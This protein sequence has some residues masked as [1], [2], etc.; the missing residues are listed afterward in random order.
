MLFAL[1]LIPVIGLLIYIYV[2]DKNEKEP[3]G[4]LIGLF[5]AGMATVITAI[6]AELIGQVILE[7]IF[8]Y[9][10]V[11]K[12]VLFAMIVVG[13][14]EELGMYVGLRLITWKSKHF[15]YSY[16]A[17]VYA[18]F[19]SL[20]FAALENIEYVFSNGIG[21]AILRMFTAI[22]GHACFAVFMGYFYSK[23]K[24]A[25]IKGDKKGQSK[26][27]CLSIFLPM[28]IHGIYDA[29]IMGGE[30]SEYDILTGLSLLLWI[31]YIIF[32]FTFSVIIVNKASKNDFCI[33]M[34]PQDI[35]TIYRP[36][37]IGKWKC[38]CGAENSLNFCSN[39]GKA[40]PVGDTWNCPRCGTLS[41]FKF[42][43]NCGT[44]KPAEAPAGQSL[45]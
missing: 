5:F 13:P 1:A 41:A 31:G 6:I 19:V 24:Y 30:A 44:P 10:P 25:K 17:I 27:T 23:A 16:D 28:V 45:S 32:L 2:K 7:F 4:L 38:I 42:C 22:P 9:A 20:G 39:C 43:G 12:M 29:I 8:P 36:S 14:A 35:Q 34:L 33:L 18:V 37:V 11:I 3:I 21:T 40:R 26:Y 15:N